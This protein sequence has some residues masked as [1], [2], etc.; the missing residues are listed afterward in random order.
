MEQF[1]DCRCVI[2]YLDFQTRIASVTITSLLISH[3]ISIA[4]TVLVTAKL[5][6]KNPSQTALHCVDQ[7]GNIFLNLFIKH[8]T[9]YIYIPIGK[10][11]CAFYQN[12]LD[13]SSKTNG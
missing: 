7:T 1:R 5:N 4:K 2:L 6:V 9:M 13:S 12:R 11:M 3:L 8:R 10:S